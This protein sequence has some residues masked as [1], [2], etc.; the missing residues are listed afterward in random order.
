MASSNPP[1]TAA[2]LGAGGRGTAY[3]QFAL[4]YPSELEVVAVAEPQPDRMARFAAHHDIAPQMRFNS[5]EDMMGAGKVADVLINCTMD[6]MHLDSTVAALNLGYHVLLE[7]PMSPVVHENIQ[8]V[9]LAEQKGLLLQVCHV[10]RYTPYFQK[11]REVVQSGRLGRIVSVD[12]RE[13]LVYWHMAHSY[14]RGNWRQTATSGPMILTKCCHDLDILTWILRQQVVKLNSFG[15]LT[16]FRPENAPEG[17]PLRCM[18]GCPAAETCKYYAPRIYESDA[19]D[20]PFNAVTYTQSAE[21]RLEALRTGPYGRCVYHSDN[22]VVDHQSVNMLLADG[23]TVSLIM[24][25]QGF[26]EGRTMRY[27]GTKATM[28]GRFS[29]GKYRITIHDHRS[30]S[31]EVIDVPERDESAH[32]GGDYGIVRSF[33]NAVKGIPDDSL[34][35]ARESLESHLLAFAAEEARLDYTTIDMPEY[36]ARV[37]AE[38]RELYR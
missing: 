28:L 12:H 21:A 17:A 30:G 6:R 37:E 27:D 11:V 2:V 24:N 38:A 29:E 8:L 13:N 4:R 26:E 5:W 31:T 9:R 18:D 34:T 10:L 14:V 1:I 23:T 25:G 19:D 33:V 22:D 36:R 32:G 15:T 20:W 3:G 16:H 7:K 35:T